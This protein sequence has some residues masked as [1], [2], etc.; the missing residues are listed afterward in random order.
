M[1]RHSSEG[2]QAIEAR[3]AAGSSPAASIPQVYIYKA[4]T[5]NLYNSITT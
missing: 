1:R 5:K 3:Y 4:I 2:E